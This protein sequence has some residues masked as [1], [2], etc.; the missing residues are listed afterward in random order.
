MSKLVLCIDDDNEDLDI[1]EEA[2]SEINLSFTCIKAHD[3]KEGLT[4]LKSTIPDYIFLDI[5]MPRMN[6]IEVLRLIRKQSRLD[7]VPVIMFSTTIPNEKELKKEGA[8]KC[9]A[10][11]S[12][13]TDLCKV[14]QTFFS[15]NGVS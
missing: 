3:G 10:K 8:T 4:F 2:L 5:N 14:L 9:I 12:T 7:K 11:S 1:F 6:G 13:F 15:S